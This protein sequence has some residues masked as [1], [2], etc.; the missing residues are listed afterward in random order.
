MQNVR[1][2]ELTSSKDGS[3]I[4]TMETRTSQL[5]SKTQLFWDYLFENDAPTAPKDGKDTDKADPS[6]SRKE[7]KFV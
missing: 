6:F 1:I 3:S 5:N 2:R 7:K 4:S